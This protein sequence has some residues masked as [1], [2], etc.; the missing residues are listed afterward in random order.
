VQAGERFLPETPREV[1]GCEKCACGEGSALAV[2]LVGILPGFGEH[3]SAFVKQRHSSRFGFV[4]QRFESCEQRSDGFGG[5]GEMSGHGGG[6][7]H[8]QAMVAVAPAGVVTEGAGD[9]GLP[10]ASVS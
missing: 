2:V 6:S 5:E 7:G 9:V 8:G 3:E 10:P 1:A 4:V